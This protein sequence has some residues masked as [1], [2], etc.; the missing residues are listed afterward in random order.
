MRISDWSSDVCSSDLHHLLRLHARAGSEHEVPEARLAFIDPEQIALHRR[1][2]VG[3]PQ[4]VRPAIF[5]VPAVRQLVRQE[6]ALAA[7][8]IPFGAIIGVA[9]V[10]DRT[11]MFEAAAAHLNR[12]TVEVG[13]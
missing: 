7:I 2:I 12:N 8:L 5:A 9:A 4:L 6:P 3:G 13:K 1:A 10:L 11:M